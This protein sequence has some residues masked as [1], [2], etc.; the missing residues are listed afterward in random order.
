MH[1]QQ[2]K[3]LP[4]FDDSLLDVSKYIVTVP[5]E[6]FVLHSIR[7]SKLHFLKHLLFKSIWF[8]NLHTSLTLHSAKHQSY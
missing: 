2:Q 1:I 6:E 4:G 7:N 5:K 3:L 8:K